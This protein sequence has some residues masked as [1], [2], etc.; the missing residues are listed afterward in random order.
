MHVSTN[1][2]LLSWYDRGLIGVDVPRALLA[3]E[4]TIAKTKPD[5]L[6]FAMCVLGVGLG[7]RA[8]TRTSSPA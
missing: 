6:F 8:W 4:M 3:V 5:A 7:L 1:A 2:R